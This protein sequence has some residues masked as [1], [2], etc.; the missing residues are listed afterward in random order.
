MAEDS[1]TSRFSIVAH[2]LLLFGATAGVFLAGVWDEG[3]IAA[4]LTIT[5]VAL[6]VCPPRVQVDWKIRAAAFA[7][8]LAAAIALLPQSW[9]GS[10]DW[11]GQLIAAGVPLPASIS[12]TPRET[13]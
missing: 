5:G 7:L 1:A 3:N 8:L 9:C 6:L 13:L 11:R 10:P 12:V 4:F 2:A